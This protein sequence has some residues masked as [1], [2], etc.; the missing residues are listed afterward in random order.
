MAANTLDILYEDNA[1]LVVNKPAGVL[2]QGDKTGDET[3][4]DLARR[5]LAEQRGGGSPF[6]VPVHRL[7]RPVSGALILARKTKTASRLGR[8]F[9]EGRVQKVYRALVEGRPPQAEMRLE[10]WI[11]KDRR[12]NTCS[13]VPAE[14]AGAAPAVLSFR[15]LESLGAGSLLEVRPETGRPHQIRV[16]LAGV[17]CPILGDLRYGARKGLG[18]MMALHC[19]SLTFT[20]PISHEPLTVTAPLPAAWKPLMKGGR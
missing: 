19:Y 6:V 3:L 2:T 11:R 15:V 13:L 20:H 1:C 18:R 7:D 8:E 17:G 12:T 4:T 16:Q 5:Y 9:R 14:S 10:G